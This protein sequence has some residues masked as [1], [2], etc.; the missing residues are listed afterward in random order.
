MPEDA[1]RTSVPDSYTKDAL[2]RMHERTMVEPMTMTETE[3]AV[4]AV[5][6]KDTTAS[7]KKKP[8]DSG[9]L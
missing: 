7:Y 6:L 5:V 9:K 2:D 1:T 4:S 8:V 3:E